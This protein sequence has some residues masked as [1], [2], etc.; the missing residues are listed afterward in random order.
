MTHALVPARASGYL[1]KDA[2]DRLVRA[3][4]VGE[5]GSRERMRAINRAYT[6]VELYHPEYLKT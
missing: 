6:Y 1:P 2:R 5:P 4:K 3:S